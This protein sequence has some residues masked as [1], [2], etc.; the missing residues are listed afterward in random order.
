AAAKADDYAAAGVPML[1]VVGPERE[2]TLAILS[3]TAVLV[4]VSLMPLWL[5]M[6]WIYGLGAASG[7]AWFLWTSW[8]LHAA[9]GPTTAMANFRASLIQLLL[10]VTGVFLQA[11]AG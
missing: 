6:G 3:H 10:L 1:P 2:W 11:L 8:R 9:P 7:G 5:D 4:A